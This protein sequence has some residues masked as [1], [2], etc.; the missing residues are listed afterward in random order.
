MPDIDDFTARY[1]TVW[2]EKDPDRRHELATGLWA[3]DAAY[4]TAGNE[5]KGRAAIE[6]A[7][8]RAYEDFVLK[9]FDFRLVGDVAAHHAGIRLTWEMTPSGSDEAAAIGEEFLI[10]DDAGMIRLDYQFMVKT[11]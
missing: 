8:T 7:V 10:L 1:V 3:E 4:V 9:G 6:A 11:P 5:H 2:N